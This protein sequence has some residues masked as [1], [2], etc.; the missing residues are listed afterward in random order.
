[1]IA[2]IPQLR[3]F[4]K[5]VQLIHLA[6]QSDAE[7]VKDAYN[8]AGIKAS[9]HGFLRKMQLA[10]SAADLV[11]CRA[12]GTTIAEITA[13]GLPSVLVPFPAASQNHQMANARELE[14]L[15]AARV[16]E[17]KYLNARTINETVIELLLNDNE[18]ERLA[19]RAACAGRPQAALRIAE[20]V[21]NRFKPRKVKLSASFMNVF[22]R[23]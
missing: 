11:L 9:V 13:M 15:G 12:G 8:K 6:G 22:E 3:K 5:R 14:S 20:K 19:G 10:Y 7:Q 17:Q 21:L 4:N 23:R 2:S 1:M 16:L 18:L